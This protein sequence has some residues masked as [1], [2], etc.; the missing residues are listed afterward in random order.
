MKVLPILAIATLTALPAHATLN[1]STQPTKN[2]SCSS[3]VCTATADD[4][5]LNVDDLSALLATTDVSVRSEGIALQ[6]I[7]VLSPLT[8]ASTHALNIESNNAIYMRN[9]ITIEGTAHLALNH[10]GGIIFDRKGAVH[11]W[12]MASGF[13]I[14]G[15]NYTLV[16]SVASLAAAVE[17]HPKGLIA[18]ANDYNAKQDSQVHT[19]P[20]SREFAGTLEGLGNKISNFAI[21]DTTENIIALFKAL[22]PKGVIENFGMTN[23][24]VLAEN[25][26]NNV[27][28][29]L[30]GYNAGTIYNCYVDGGTV[31]T[32]FRGTLG[33]LVAQNYGGV[34]QS[35]ANVSVEG[36]QIAEVGGLIGNAH[37]R[38]QDVY[39]IG[40]VIAGDQSDVGGLIGYNFGHVKHG[41]ATGHVSGGQNARVGGLMG[42]TQ[43]PVRQTYWNTETSGTQ[44]GIG[45]TNIE[46]ITGLTTAE[47]Q[48]ELPKGFALGTWALDAKINGGMPFLVTNP[49]RK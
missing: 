2:V 46:G 42:T 34:F 29:G 43:L 8:W 13:S 7:E 41:Y 24:N 20:V 45:G 1:L 26:F 4:A 33:G 10:N 6:D 39:A 18:F 28:A 11:Y 27:A 35:W 44:F 17:K 31:R 32:D 30:V 21:W 19:V 12:D 47:L 37:G 40:R 3:G 36:A 15:A 48:A 14:N 23:V 9:V 25:T 49:P 22:K 5:V 38:V 16:N